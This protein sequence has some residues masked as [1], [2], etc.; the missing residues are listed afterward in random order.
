[1]FCIIRMSSKSKTNKGELEVEEI[2]ERRLFIDEVFE[3]LDTYI[4]KNGIERY[5]DDGDR[6]RLG[7]AELKRLVK[8]QHIKNFYYTLQED[9]SVYEWYRVILQ[10]DF[11]SVFVYNKK[12]V[13]LL[14]PLTK[15][16]TTNISF[17]EDEEVEMALKIMDADPFVFK[18]IINFGKD[19][20]REEFIVKLYIRN[21][22]PE[23][24]M[25]KPTI[26]LLTNLFKVELDPLNST[27]ATFM[28]KLTDL[29]T[30]LFI[31]D[32]N[33]TEDIKRAVTLLKYTFK[34][35]NLML[36]ST[37]AS[38]RMSVS[39]VSKIPIP[40][41]TTKRKT[42]DFYSFVEDIIDVKV[43]NFFEEIS[44][45][46]TK[47]LLRKDETGLAIYKQWFDE[48]TE[49]I[50]GFFIK[51]DSI[52][53][54]YKKFKD[55]IEPYVFDDAYYYLEYGSDGDDD[56][57]DDEK[58]TYDFYKPKFMTTYNFNRIK[59]GI[60]TFLNLDFCLILDLN[61][62]DDDEFRE[63]IYNCYSRSKYNT[64]K[65]VEKFKEYL[66]DIFYAGMPKNIY[67][68]KTAV[69]EPVLDIYKEEREQI[70][71]ELSSFLMFFNEVAYDVNKKYPLGSDD[72]F[73][74]I[75][76]LYLEDEK[77]DITEKY[78]EEK[79]KL[80]LMD[81]FLEEITDTVE[82]EGGKEELFFIPGNDFDDNNL[83]DYI[84]FI[85]T[86]YEDVLSF[87]KK[88]KPAS[89]SSSKSA[90]KSASKSSSKSSTEL[91]NLLEEEFPFDTSKEIDKRLKAILKK[92][93][94]SNV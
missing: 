49:S 73:D 20:E 54:D 26:T 79:I 36:P 8:N 19:N 35:S 56:D 47:V 60:V 32:Y 62:D 11:E 52:V 90:S 63:K 61:D 70:L 50:H 64:P 34:F 7:E 10:E 23:R 82:I 28:K 18:D 38:S 66:D 30:N 12:L 25:Q 37:L 9:P 69:K 16:K 75:I 68:E 88:E 59:K 67:D 4:D 83:A 29:R 94:K 6:A 80:F 72:S 27:H 92:K 21:Y 85:N 65:K 48:Y 89:K 87:L 74:E 93:I 15:D 78:D 45:Q 2:E 81:W 84:E 53:F 71:K 76:R 91:R 22:I 5:T 77:I 51:S 41:S 1:M 13:E 86:V 43:F 42:T 44:Y 33:E 31:K 3:V 55:A 24:E 58:T 46:F 14:K 39:A 40:A 57:D 17:L